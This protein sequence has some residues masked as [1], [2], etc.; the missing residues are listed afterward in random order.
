MPRGKSRIGAKTG[1]PLPL[2]AASSRL[3]M[4]EK[5]GLTEDKLGALLAKIAAQAELYLDDP[6]LDPFAKAAW[7]KMM[8]RDIM[9]VRPPKAPTSGSGSQAPVIINIG[10]APPEPGRKARPL[11]VAQGD[12]IIDITPNAP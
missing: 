4:L 11:S 1:L 5:A 10:D 2:A 12:D 9:D 6:E 3:K 8:V 7:A